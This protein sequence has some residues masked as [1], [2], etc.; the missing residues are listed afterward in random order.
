MESRFNVQV[1]FM[2]GLFSL[3]N[4]VIVAF[5]SDMW[6]VQIWGEKCC[7]MDIWV[8]PYGS[9]QGFLATFSC[10][11]C[12]IQYIKL[13]LIDLIQNTG[14]LEHQLFRNGWLI[15]CIILYC[16]LLNGKSS[17]LVLQQMQPFKFFFF[18]DI[19]NFFTLSFFEELIELHLSLQSNLVCA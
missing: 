3:R 2:C 14:C 1:L 7:W 17:D 6:R 16:A 19:H 12:Y 10:L 9:A 18:I 11:V 13:F 5:V 15:Y 4:I 8:P